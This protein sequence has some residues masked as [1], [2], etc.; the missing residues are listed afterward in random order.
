[1][2]TTSDRAG[3]TLIELLIVLAL[4]GI[5]AAVMIP[6]LMAARTTAN[7]RT[8]QIY[9]H[10]VFTAGT[11][12]LASDAARTFPTG[13][14]SG[15]FNAGAYTVASPPTSAVATCDVGDANGDGQVDV[16]VTA[17]SGRIYVVP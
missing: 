9:A 5:L 4:V 17:Q 2:K 12:Y 15:G 14:C 8:A 3:F 10:D 1:M 11:A 6:S 13:D 16:S 7:D